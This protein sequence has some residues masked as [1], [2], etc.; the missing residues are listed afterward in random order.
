MSTPNRPILDKK[1]KFARRFAKKVTKYNY[2]NLQQVCAR[3]ENM[4]VVA[5]KTI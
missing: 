3:R 4:L 5:K 2:K 1:T